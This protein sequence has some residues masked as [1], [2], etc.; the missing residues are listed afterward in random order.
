MCSAVHKSK[1]D[2]LHVRLTELHVAHQNLPPA[3]RTLHVKETI[4]NIYQK[5]M[6]FTIVV[7][8]YNVHIVC[9]WAKFHKNRLNR[10]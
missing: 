10:G 3:V 7:L 5:R 1:V 8:T 6:K 2:V 9:H 4:Q